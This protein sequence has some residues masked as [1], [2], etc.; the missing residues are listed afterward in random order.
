LSDTAVTLARWEAEEKAVRAKQ[1]GAA[2]IDVRTL[3]DIPGIEV[4]KRVL[5]GEIPL[6][7]IQDTLDF[8][9]LEAEPGRALFQGRPAHKFYNPIG[10]IHGGWYAALLDSA[11]GCAV[12][13]ALPAGKAYTTLEFK[14]N[15]VRALT[16]RVPLVRVEGKA[17]HVGGQVA[18]SEARL[19]DAEGRLYAHGTTTCLVFAPRSHQAHPPATA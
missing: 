14:V 11:L 8:I 3:A 7:P 16:D 12:H 2:A 18:T 1:R 19:F 5:A 13:C 17:V 10:S 4:F 9:L 15:M 6:A